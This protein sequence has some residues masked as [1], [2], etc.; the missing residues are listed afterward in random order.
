MPFDYFRDLVAALDNKGLLRHVTAEVD[1]DWE[2]STVARQVFLNMPEHQRYALQFDHV[3]GFD[4]PV[5]VGAFGGSREVYA[6]GIEATPGELLERWANALCSPI[7]PELV[8]SAP[9]QE[10]VLTGKDVD[11]C[12]FPVPTW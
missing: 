5:V 10:V 2:I 8:D 7:Q 11:L 12:R 6:F 4:M 1:K 3:R 9:C